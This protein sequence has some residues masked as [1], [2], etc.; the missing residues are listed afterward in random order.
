ME[1]KQ[2]QKLIEYLDFYYMNDNEFRND[3]FSKSELLSK[4]EMDWIIQIYKQSKTKKKYYLDKDNIYIYSWDNRKGDKWTATSLK[5]L[6]ERQDNMI[7][8]IQFWLN[9]YDIKNIN[10]S[11]INKISHTS[12]GLEGKIV[13]TFNQSNI[14]KITLW[15]DNNKNNI[16][17][18]FDLYKKDLNE[19]TF[20]GIL[21]AIKENNRQ[22]KPRNVDIINLE[23]NEINDI[24]LTHYDYLEYE[25]LLELIDIKLNLFNNK[26]KILEIFNKWQGA[27][28]RWTLIEELLTW[29]NTKNNF[30]D[31]LLELE[32]MD[33]FINIK[34]TD[35]S[36]TTNS[37]P[38][39]FNINKLFK[40]YKQTII[41]NKKFL[42]FYLFIH[43]NE[44]G[45]IEFK[46]ANFLDISLINSYKI[47]N[48]WWSRNENSKWNTQISW[49]KKCYPN[50]N[51]NI[52][53]EKALSFCNEMNKSDL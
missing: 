34:T 10:L 13:W 22:I 3:N 48:T 25:K 40:S 2:L 6:F 18:I 26:D 11:S 32:D 9:W 15:L 27:K 45:I 1:Y 14:N 41:N 4:M 5:N 20:N 16:I 29:K 33:I 7:I 19:K 38:V 50:I 17:P 46:I 44:T 37:S 36:I 31:L 24:I 39:W 42:F 23:T 49:F 30:E 35:F 52:N 21:S 8:F 53:K 28:K 51:N 47:Q 12:K 43:K